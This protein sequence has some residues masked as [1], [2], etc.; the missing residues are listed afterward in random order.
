MKRIITKEV[1]RILDRAHRRRSSDAR[2]SGFLTS[3]ASMRSINFSFDA[4]PN[5]G[6][7]HFSS[8]S[9]FRR[10]RSL[11]RLDIDSQRRWYVMPE[12]NFSFDHSVHDDHPL[13]EY[14]STCLSSEDRPQDN[15]I[16]TDVALYFIGTGGSCPTKDRI[17]STTL[18]R[19][20]PQ[21]FLFDVGEGAQRQLM[22][23]RMTLKDISKI[24]ITHMHADHILGLPGMLLFL[25]QVSLMRK[26]NANGS[27]EATTIDIYGPPGLF[28]YIAM[29]LEL[30]RAGKLASSF[31]VHELMGS[32]E[33]RVVSSIGRDPRHSNFPEFRRPNLTR[34]AIPRNPDGTWTIETPSMKNPLDRLDSR[35]QG[36]HIFAAEIEHVHRVPTFG[37]TVREQDPEF[38]IDVEKARA[39]GIAPG[40]KY[41]LLKAGFGAMSDDE[42]RMVQPEEVL[43]DQVRRK[44]RKFAF[45]GDN[46]K[47]S[48]A[49]AM[50]C[51][52]C[53]VL[54]H[55]ATVHDDSAS[56]AIR[57]GH[58]TPGMAGQVAQEVNAQVL[59]LNH[60]SAK[61]WADDEL[62]GIVTAAETTNKGVSSVLVA[63]DFMEIKV[64]LFGFN[65]TQSQGNDE[66]EESVGD[67][68]L[69]A[70]EA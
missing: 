66:K 68:A 33:D 55:E 64:P 41:R 23:T 40:R 17:C 56:E 15:P 32:D 52:D 61:F 11:A 31:V 29:T 13:S 4:I 8:A 63:H 30:S 25:N 54:V 21:S 28:N 70:E 49:M 43:T 53:D 44:A 46:S 59:V 57:R 45:V 60:I 20:G 26:H 10:V 3:K 35:S 6:V 37:Y 5:S 1:L 42:T 27:A 9:T 36:F 22:F 65:S 62:S 2:S 50:L 12:C 67:T 69:A 34:K 39:C 18:L 38:R 51:Q 14:I 47:F 16:D 48:P 58:S 24:F 19:L 7:I